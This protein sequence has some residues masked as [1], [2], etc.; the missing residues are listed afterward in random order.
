MQC[1]LFPSN[2]VTAKM[3]ILVR[4]KFT[5]KLCK[6]LFHA[7]YV[8]LCSIL[9]VSVR[10]KMFLMLPSQGFSPLSM[11]TQPS[12]FPKMTGSIFLCH[13][14]KSSGRQD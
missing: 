8:N 13:H 7:N 5:F 3:K 9:L 10:N 2:M 11:I 4:V 1:L 12:E 14:R 6:S